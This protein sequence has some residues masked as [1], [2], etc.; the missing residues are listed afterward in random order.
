MLVVRA[1]LVRAV[2]IAAVLVPLAVIAGDGS[3][4]AST[5]S[6]E[7]KPR[8]GKMDDSTSGHGHAAGALGNSSD[9]TGAKGAGGAGSNAGTE[10]A[11]RPTAAGETGTGGTGSSG[12]AGGAGGMKGHADDRTVTGKLSKVS[13][14]SVTIESGQG[15]KHEL[16]LVGQTMIRMNGKDASRTQLQEGQE[17]RASFS[18]HGGQQVAVRIE[19]GAAEK[20]GAAGAPGG[21][22]KAGGVSA[23]SSDEAKKSR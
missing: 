2:S 10:G 20:G 19:A 22:P 11:G 21:Q 1:V 23:G 4:A 17:V 9:T 16:K 18:E 14:D 5:S 13:Q 3:P 8:T 12:E 15:E 6:E 7:G